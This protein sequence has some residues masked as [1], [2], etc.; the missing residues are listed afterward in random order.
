[1]R[2]PFGLDAAI[3]GSVSTCRRFL[4]DVFGDVVVQNWVKEL[5]ARVP[6]D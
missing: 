2:R 1:M 3:W 6:V 5:K 4:H